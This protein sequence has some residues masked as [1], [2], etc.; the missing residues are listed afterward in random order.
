MFEYAYAGALVAHIISVMIT[1]GAVTVTD[2]LH[3][4]GLRNPKFEKQ[5]LF[6]FPTLSKLITIA[7]L[8]IYATGLIMVVADP[9]L[10]ESKLFLAKLFLVLI[11]TGNGLF[12]HHIIF[13]R[14]EK[15]MKKKSYDPQFLFLAAFGGSLSITTWYAIVV[16]AT[17]KQLAYSPFWFFLGYVIA[18]AIS[19]GVALQVEKRRR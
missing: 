6:V 11:V 8:V 16:L 14:I 2:Y 19:F 7:L 3:I 12:L 1:V 17:T 10:L 18:F 4:L 13:P 5:T 9:V 15:Q